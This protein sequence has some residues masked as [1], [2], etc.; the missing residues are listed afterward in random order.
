MQCNWDEN[1]RLRKVRPEKAGDAPGD[2]WR[3]LPLFLVATMAG[4]ALGLQGIENRDA[5]SIR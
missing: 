5:L 3:C 2:I 1:Q 4:A